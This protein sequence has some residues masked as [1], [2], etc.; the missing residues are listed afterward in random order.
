ME[1]LRVDSLSAGYKDKQIINNVTF[2]ADIGD[3]I[4]IVGPNGCGK[5]TLLRAISGLIKIHGGEVRIR[6]KDL[7]NMGR[8]EI[9]KRIAFVPQM[10]EPTEGF[11]V[12]D[13][14]ML[15]RNP[16]L[17]RFSF[18]SDKD[19]K[20]VKW[21]IEELKVEELVDVPVNN[22]SGGEFQRVAV[23]RA[24]AQQPNILLLDEP[25]SHLDFRFQLRVLRMLRR[26]REDKLIVSV[27]HDLNLA[28]R[29][30]RKIILMNKGE[31]LAWGRTDDVITSDNLR[32]AYRIRLDVRK[33][34]K[35]GKLR[36]F[37]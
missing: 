25:T 5:T 4:G 15:G 37:S 16:F 26:I 34:P 9:A 1:L 33:N 11:T 29:F 3:F 21:A 8:R 30:C 36:I 27:F 28:A 31:I 12:E 20:I 6:G 24:L 22:L 19:Y 35:T 13:E 17:N 14:V 23:A 32:K 18:E 10:M 2:D 7:K